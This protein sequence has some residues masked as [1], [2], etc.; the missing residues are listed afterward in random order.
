MDPLV[1][2][3]P[4]VVTSNRTFAVRH[5]ALRALKVKLRQAISVSELAMLAPLV[6]LEQVEPLLRAVLAG[7]FGE[8]MVEETESAIRIK[9]PR[10]FLPLRQE[11]LSNR[12]AWR[13]SARLM[14]IKDLVGLGMRVAVLTPDPV[15]YELA[16]PNFVD[17]AKAVGVKSE[18]I[19]DLHK[20]AESDGP[21]SISYPRD[22]FVQL[23]DT[24]YLSPG[25]HNP[26]NWEKFFAWANGLRRNYSRIGFG[27]EVVIGDRFALISDPY[28]PDMNMLGLNAIERFRMQS[29]DDILTMT[30][31]GEAEHTLQRKGYQ[32]FRIPTGWMDLYPPEVL[33]ELG[34]RKK[35]QLPSDHAD[36]Q[37]LFLPQERGLFFDEEYYRTNRGL[38]DQ[39]LEQV[40]PNTFRTIPD[41]DG[42]PINSL[43][44]PNGGVYVDSMAQ[45]AIKILRQA[46]IEVFP[47]SKPF[48]TWAWGSNAGIHCSTNQVNLLPS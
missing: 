34:I 26:Y 30:T 4:V 35:L 41:E 16:N 25:E 14:L 17:Q 23:E 42:L 43:P 44:L 38:L 13:D 29:M 31:I 20:E 40:R 3:K 48:G 27:G 28:K 33:A 8:E 24:V 12:E 1:G 45:N 9:D 11:M 47:S 19:I 10:I 32:T 22:L 39:I 37:V 5:D 36:M 21:G 15:V 6:N 7:Q 18:D 2:P 46:G